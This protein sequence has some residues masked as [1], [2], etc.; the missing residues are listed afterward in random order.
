MFLNGAE[1]DP[2]AVDY[3]GVAPGYAGVYQI[4]ITIPTQGVRSGDNIPLQVRTADG[5]VTT[6]S[7]VVISI[8]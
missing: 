3:V 4:N 5:S 7:Q 8:K 1:L 2:A 6:T